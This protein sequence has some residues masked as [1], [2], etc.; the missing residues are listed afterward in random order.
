MISNQKQLNDNHI[1]VCICTYK[2]PQMLS[3]LFSKLQDQITENLFTYSAVVVDNDVNKSASDI[4]A[5]W[6]KNAT[7]QIDYYCE[8]QQNIA[9]ARNKAVQNAK[10]NFIAFI[11]DDEHPDD[12]WLLHLFNTK[13]KYKSAGVLGPVIPYFE[14]E[15]PQ[16]IIKGNICERKTFTTGTI[17]RNSN[18][19]RTGNVLL[20]KQLFSNEKNLFDISYGKTG[21]EDTNFFSRM[22]NQ[23]LEFV[24]CNEACVYETVPPE[25]FRRTYYL[26]RSLM[27]GLVASKNTSMISLSTL[28]SLIAFFSYTLILPIL[29]LLR[30]DIFMKY[31][32]SD[33]DH[34]GKLLGLCGIKSIKEKTF[35]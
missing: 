11:D 24:W 35:Y 12:N 7:I 26:K 14:I 30:H 29:F 32:I 31:L 23:G 18:D 22:F 6:K 10:G 9:L 15:A 25:R 19:T 8:P 1:S 4:V 16:W 27:R 3:N 17:I 5:C 33:C 20:D 2:R 13:I 21:G 34:I 28:K